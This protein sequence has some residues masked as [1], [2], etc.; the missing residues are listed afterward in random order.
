MQLGSSTGSFKSSQTFLMLSLVT[1]PK[2]AW[3]PRQ[4]TVKTIRLLNR[5]AT[6]GSMLVWRGDATFLQGT[7]WCFSNFVGGGE[8]RNISDDT[9]YGALP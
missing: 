5:N 8:V 4:G 1:L 2:L 9:G 6:W 3:N 7:G